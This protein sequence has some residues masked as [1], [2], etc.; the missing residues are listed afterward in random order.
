L[1]RGLE[2]CTDKRP[3]MSDLR[4]SGSLEQDADI[5]LFLYRPEI[6]DTEVNDANRGVVEV[7]VSKHRNGPVG[8][9]NLVF[10][11]KFARFD[12]MGDEI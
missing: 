2:S 9:A 11:S 1:S 3:M 8:T 4:E 6:Y 10:R 5:V 7:I 12:D